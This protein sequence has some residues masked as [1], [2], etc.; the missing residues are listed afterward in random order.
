MRTYTK[1][2]IRAVENTT[3]LQF[4]GWYDMSYGQLVPLFKRPKKQPR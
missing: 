2:Q 1:T 3:G 4:V